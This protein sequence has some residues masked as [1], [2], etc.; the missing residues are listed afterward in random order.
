VEQVRPQLELRNH[1]LEVRGLDH[2]TCVEGDRTRLTQIVANLLGNAVRYTPHGGQVALA[3][4]AEAGEAVVRV[5]DSGIGIAPEF[6]PHV[7]ELFSQQSVG[8]DREHGG[9]GLGLALVHRLVTLHGGRVSAASA[10]VGQGA[11]FTVRLP[12]AGGPA[13]D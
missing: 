2:A 9:L 1:R 4:D 3:L 5:S 13:A 12:L 8:V 10:G 6:L 11:T 7:F